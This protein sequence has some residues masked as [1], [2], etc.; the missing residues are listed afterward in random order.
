MT[1]RAV[2]KVEPGAHG[3]M[4]SEYRRML[5]EVFDEKQAPPRAAAAA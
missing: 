3:V 2:T 4:Q 5:K 1:I